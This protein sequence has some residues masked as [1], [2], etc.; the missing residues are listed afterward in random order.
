MSEEAI[1]EEDR[2]GDSNV[3]ETKDESARQ[4]TEQAVP[5]ESGTKE[6]ESAE[7][8]G[9]A[10]TPDGETAEAENRES[11]EYEEYEEYEISLPEGSSLDPVHLDEIASLATELGLSGEQAQAWVNRESEIVTDMLHNALTIV[12]EQSQAA[13]A[14]ASK[15]WA[16]EVKND[17]EIGGD[18][19]N[20]TVE[21]TKRLMESY[22][23][24][25]ILNWL[26]ETGFGNHPDAIRGIYKIAKRMGV[27]EDKFD[28]GNAP[29]Q[30]QK[31][32]DAELFY[33]NAK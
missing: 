31:K 30:S 12:N 27:G 14:E 21:L 23:T 19:L 20:E 22:F 6:A 10:E 5:E 24:E 9:E 8:S 4:N 25:E 3:A 29:G 28:S 16:E 7:L 13:M 26:D 32:T 33:G 18:K 1:F 11:D 2:Q 15:Q 17:P